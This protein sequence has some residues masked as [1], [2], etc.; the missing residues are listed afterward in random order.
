LLFTDN[1]VIYDDD[2]DDD[3]DCDWLTDN[4]LNIKLYRNLVNVL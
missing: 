3:D 2:D 1:N 4:F